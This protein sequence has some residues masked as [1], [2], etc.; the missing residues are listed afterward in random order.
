M[1]YLRL[2]S[3][4]TMHT[5]I[6]FLL[7]LFSFQ[8]AGQIPDYFGNNPT[9]HCGLGNTDQWSGWPQPSQEHY[10][11][12]LNGDTVI[13][14]NTY[15][16]VFMRGVFDYIM[17]PPP[18]DSTYDV[19]SNF[20]VRQQG[21]SIY[22]HIESENQ[23]YLLYNYDLQ[24]G[25]FPTGIGYESYQF[26]PVQKIDSLLIN[27]EYRRRIYM[28][29]IA[30]PVIIEGI[31]HQLYPP[32]QSGLEEFGEFLQPVSEG[33]GFTYYIYCYGQNDQ[34]L[35]DPNGNGGN[36]YLN[37][38]LEEADTPRF[39]IHPNPASDQVTMEGLPDEDLL[40]T[41]IDTQGKRVLQSTERRFSVSSLT[42]GMYIVV[43]ESSR[44]V[45]C[46]KLSVL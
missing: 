2:Q 19:P 4:N 20:F 6:I 41:F 25:D 28:D 22:A 44:G 33:I 30:G 8:S 37:V 32:P 7:C 14:G 26:E 40:I 23:N 9:W 1:C 34:P 45:V 21:R 17:T 35:W 27:G 10:V 3:K 36:C 15:H 16:R 5:R 43:I 13:S 39:S 11:Y 24:V 38:G 31:G 46:E 42:S 12:Y 18:I 29:S